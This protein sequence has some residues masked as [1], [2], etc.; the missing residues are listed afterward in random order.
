MGN[1]TELL[2]LPGE[3]IRAGI[4]RVLGAAVLSQEIKGAVWSA[5]TPRRGEYI[6]WVLAPHIA[7]D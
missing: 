1:Y 5:V 6:P 4:A 3:F 2:T 7:T